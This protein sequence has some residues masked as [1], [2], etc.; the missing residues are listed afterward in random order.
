MH[1]YNLA[2]PWTAP[3]TDPV[4]D[5][6]EPETADGEESPADPDVFPSLSVS[7][8]FSFVGFPLNLLQYDR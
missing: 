2:G 6:L 7:F 3:D 4:F 1:I 5:I 8:S